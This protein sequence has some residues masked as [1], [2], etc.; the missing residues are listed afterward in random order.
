MS[1][2]RAVAK[3]VE[4]V[5]VVWWLLWVGGFRGA[6]GSMTMCPYLQIIGP[7]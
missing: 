3:A 7:R 4:V 5:A 6:S 2:A 1:R